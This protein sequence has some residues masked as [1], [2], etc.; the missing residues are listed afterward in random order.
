MSVGLRGV[1]WEE[2]GHPVP[3]FSKRMAAE[4]EYALLDSCEATWE[5]NVNALNKNK[6]VLSELLSTL[7]FKCTEKKK[8]SGQFWC[9]HYCFLK[10]FLSILLEWN[11]RH[12]GLMLQ[13]MVG[14]ITKYRD[15]ESQAPQGTSNYPI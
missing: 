13:Q 2:K 10:I 3:A 14:F 11:L 15:M 8:M 5:N 6:N 7:R 9:S 4:R 12:W 1:S